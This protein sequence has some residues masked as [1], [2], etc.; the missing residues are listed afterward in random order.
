[1]EHDL[2]HWFSDKQS[3]LAA[4]RMWRQQL[5]SLT[6]YNLLSAVAIWWKYVPLVNKSIDPWRSDTWP[7]PWELVGAGEFCTSAQGL[8]I[9]Y[10]LS[11]LGHDCELL[12]AQIPEQKETRLLVLADDQKLL[13]YV[14]GEVISIENATL[15]VLERWRPSDLARLVKV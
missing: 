13:N 12:L 14:D 10:T 5:Q 6:D 4:W 1:M 11:L 15:E 3:R 7:T 9:F 2:S 8:G